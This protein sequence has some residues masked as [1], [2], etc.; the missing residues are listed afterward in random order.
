MSDTK[1][2][3]GTTSKSPT[4]VAYQVRDREGQK[5]FWYLITALG[6]T[7]GVGRGGSA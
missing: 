2:T 3:E 4:H 1:P 5:G 7:L 6:R